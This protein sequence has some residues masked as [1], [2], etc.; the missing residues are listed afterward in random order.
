MLTLTLPDG[1]RLD[2][3]EGPGERS[4]PTVVAHHGTPGAATRDRTLDRDAAAAGVRLVTF[5]RPGYGGSTRR[6][7]R[8]VA[9]VADDVR[10]LLD[11]LGVERCATI[12]ASGGGPHALATAAGLGD[13]VTGV[14]TVAGVAPADAAGLDFLAGMGEDNVEEFGR[15]TRGEDAVRSFVESFPEALGAADA[16]TLV[17]SMATVLPEV[18]REVV[19]GEHGRELGEDLAAS[20][21]EAVSAGVDGWVDD[22]LAFVRA[23]G[24]DLDDVRVPTYVWQGEL[25]LM[26]PPAHG[27]WLAGRLPRTE[28]RLLAGHGHLSLTAAHG[29]EMLTALRRT[30]RP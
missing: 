20:M 19:R 21:A 26:V 22:D 13:R 5:S 12:G 7:G 30:L 18:D 8:D 4:L 28:P 17:S 29:V 6:P 24:F 11:H 27:R 3:D 16:A 9:D 25:D 23:W 2:Y 10:A 1:R 15:A 14:V